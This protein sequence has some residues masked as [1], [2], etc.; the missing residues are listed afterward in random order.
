MRIDRRSFRPHRLLAVF[1]AVIAPLLLPAP[2]S[3]AQSP[4]SAQSAASPA[5]S[6]PWKIIFDRS[7]ITRRRV[8]DDWTMPTNIFAV[9]MDKPSA[10]LKLTNDNLSS[11]PVSSPDGNRIAFV[12]NGYSGGIFVMDSD[13]TNVRRI[14][15]VPMR[16]GTLTWSP[17]SKSFAF[18]VD[19]ANHFDLQPEGVERQIYIADVTAGAPPKLLADG[20]ASPSWSPDGTQIAY[21]CVRS[22]GAGAKLACI[23]AISTSANSTP[24]TLI[25]NARNPSWSPD[26]QRIL[27]VSTANHESELFVARSDGSNPK[28]ISDPRH[29]VISA[30][31][32]PDGKRI[33]FTSTRTLDASYAR[34]AN[35]E[36]PDSMSFQGDDSHSIDPDINRRG[37]GYSAGTTSRKV[38]ELFVASADGSHTFQI[39]A[40]QTVRCNQFLW[41]PDSV[42]IAGICAS[43]S[44]DSHGVA[45][46]LPSDSVFLLD[47]NKPNS[48]PRIIARSGIESVSTASTVSR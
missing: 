11:R 26:G 13:G 42:S 29:D 23:C 45:R 17:N 12:R 31:W 35:F 18:D 34:I 9:N 5:T 3:N 39:G 44:D 48:K 28:R 14:T 1:I 30:A 36:S 19:A 37:T 6:Q 16:V 7:M 10:E 41:S 22:V 40:K 24:H 38:P 43:G 15:D 27:Y 4:T 2:R 8:F 46:L 20:G 47:I 32:S 33:A 25:D 21:A